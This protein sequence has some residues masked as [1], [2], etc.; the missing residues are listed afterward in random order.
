LSAPPNVSEF[1]LNEGKLFLFYYISREATVIDIE[2]GKKITLERIFRNLIV[3]KNEIY[4]VRTKSEDDAFRKDD[5]YYIC[6]KDMYG[7]ED[8]LYET[9]DYVFSF[10]VLDESI[11]VSQGIV[12][13]LTK[14]MEAKADDISNPQAKLIQVQLEDGKET[15]IREDLSYFTEIYSTLNKLYFSVE[16]WNGKR[17]TY[18]D[19]SLDLNQFRLKER[20]F[21][22]HILIDAWT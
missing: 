18:H 17:W 16:E 4:Y 21:S 22:K 13:N 10:V 3:R 11:L 19:E 14:S 7:E 2:T 1:R 5:V 12:N 15:V 8:T 6:K 9:T 20:F